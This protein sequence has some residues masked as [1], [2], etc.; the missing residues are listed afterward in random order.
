MKIGIITFQR[1]HNFG[2]QMQMFALSTFLK[3]IGHDVSVLDFRNPNI[4]DIYV[5]FFNLRRY[6]FRNVFKGLKIFWKDFRKFYL[7]FAHSKIRK[8]SAFTKENVKLTGGF[9]KAE[10]M[11]ID[12]DILIVGSDQVWNYSIIGE[13]QKNVYFLDDRSDNPS[14]PKRISYAASAEINDY[15]YLI[16]DR[17]YVQKALNNFSWIST[18]EQALS[19]LLGNKLQIKSESILD[20]TL[21]LRSEDYIKIAIKPKRDRYLFVYRV[22][23]T[24]YLS[25]LAKKISQEC[26]LEIIE[27]HA[28]TIPCC[29][30]ESYGPREILGFICYAEVVVTSSF[31]GTSLSIINRKD[32]YAAYDDHSERVD[33]LL[34]SVNLS[35]RSLLS[36]DDYNGFT[37]IT[38][39]DKVING[40]ILH[41]KQWLLNAINN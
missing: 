1:A 25:E 37:P 40:Y 23:H 2:A 33:N 20:P 26:G 4:D 13:K 29:C 6:R 34:K 8:F 19:D 31:H 22:N 17:E 38:F 10:D 41:S 12:F 11:P 39:D 24:S 7:P 30:E 5:R 14:F 35:E 9:C 15:H 32:F 36:L 27:A 28:S 21:L 18:R 3:S 16:D